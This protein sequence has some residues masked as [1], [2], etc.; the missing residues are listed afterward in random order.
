ME[1]AD[2]I[3]RLGFRRWYERQLIDGFASLVT[4]LLC[5]IV[6][7][8]CREAAEFRAL[9]ARLASL[10]LISFGAGAAAIV[11]VRRFLS[12]LARAERYGDKSTCASCGTYARFELLADV[13]GV[14]SVRCR[15]CHHE[16]QL[17]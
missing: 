9:N 11:A 10:L 15:K 4:A 8:A 16:W 1:P 12:V 5:T 13:A 3:R 7:L 6:I 14:L 2:S 17:P